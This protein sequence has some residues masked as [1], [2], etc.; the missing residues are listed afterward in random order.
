MLN[1]ESPIIYFLAIPPPEVT[2]KSSTKV[3]SAE[4]GIILENEGSKV[5]TSDHSHT[6]TVK[7]A[8]QF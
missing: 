8:T 4:V 6:Q 1:N 7:L 5:T 2:P 3:I